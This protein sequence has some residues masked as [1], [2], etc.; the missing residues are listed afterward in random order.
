[1]KV[2]ENL[3]VSEKCGCES[4]GVSVSLEEKEQE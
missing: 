1:M 2:L 3:E 4:A